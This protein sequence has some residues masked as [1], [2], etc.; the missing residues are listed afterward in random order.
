[1]NLGLPE[2]WRRFPLGLKSRPV[3]TSEGVRG[4]S[5]PWGS[6]AQSASECRGVLTRPAAS[7][8]NLIRR[9]L[10]HSPFCPPSSVLCPLPPALCP[11][12]LLPAVRNPKGCQ[13]VAGGRRGL[14]GG[15][16]R[17][18]PSQMS[19]TPAGRARKTLPAPQ[20]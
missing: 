10:N 19:C 3:G 8:P 20:E 16:L 7:S 5:L 17:V 13:R 4:P 15:D 12:P 18:M 6:G 1:M 14:A 2:S 11:L 9:S